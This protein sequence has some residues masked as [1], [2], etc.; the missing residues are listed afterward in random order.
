MDY[1]SII[2]RPIEAEL[3]DFIALFNRSLSND[4]GML[5]WL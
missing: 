4:E 5:G 3:N 1:L 2:K